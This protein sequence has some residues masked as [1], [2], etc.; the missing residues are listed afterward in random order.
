[1][2]EKI[3][4]DLIGIT[5]NQ[6]ESGVYAVILQQSGGTRR[7]PIIIGSAEAQSIEC[8]LQ[9]VVTPRPLTHDLMVNVMRA[10]G[11][12]LDEIQLRRLPSGVFAAD[13]VLNDGSTKI[14]IDS[15]SSDAIALAVRIG[16]PIYTSAEVLEEA[17]FDPESRAE[18]QPKAVRKNNESKSKTPDEDLSSL[19]LKELERAMQKAVDSEKYEEAARIKKEIDSRTQ[20]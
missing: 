4:L 5:Y 14:V 20:D 11:V 15:R 18:K 8:K 6:I 2:D 16:A 3:K 13:L 10:Y 19:T 12:Q 1:M 9:E 7:I 17:G